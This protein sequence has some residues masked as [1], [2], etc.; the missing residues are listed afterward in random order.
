MKV[1]PAV[2]PALLTRN[3]IEWLRGKIRLSQGYQRKIKSD[4]RKKIKI[5]NELEVPLL[6]SSGLI[7]GLA[8][9]A[10][11]NAA[12]ANCNIGV[13]EVPILQLNNV[14]HAQISDK[15]V[16]RKGFEPSTPAMS[17]R[18]L[19]QAR[20]PALNLDVRPTDSVIIPFWALHT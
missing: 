16:G 15:I 20:P 3:E 8:A 9:T 11:C 18:Y 5:F 14:N 2:K 13:S 17:R 19:N 1:L 12:T 10:N 6:L 4:I 7:D